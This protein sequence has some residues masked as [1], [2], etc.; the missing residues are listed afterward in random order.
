MYDRAAVRERVV[1]IA[2]PVWITVRRSI[3]TEEV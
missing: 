2:S 3:V 1:L